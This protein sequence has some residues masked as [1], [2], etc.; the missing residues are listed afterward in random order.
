MA[1]NLTHDRRSQNMAKIRA[2]DTKPEM[3]VRRLLHAL[4]Y[5]FRLHK[6]DLPGKPD[7]VFAS[8]KKV[9]FIHGCFWHQ[10]SSSS[11]KIARR[12]KSRGEYWNAKLD[13]NVERDGE[14]KK[15]LA[16]A[17]WGSMTIWECQIRK[18]PAA[19]ARAAARFLDR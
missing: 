9:I 18:H 1:D 3:T 11:C 15:A 16:R 17:G 13:R 12:P 6:G 14:V 4:G 19:V 8:R 7:L 5:R 2:R 10:H